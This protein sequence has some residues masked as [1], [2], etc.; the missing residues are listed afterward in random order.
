MDTAMRDLELIQERTEDDSPGRKAAMLGM[1]GLSTVALVFAMGVV[2]GG[3][4]SEAD[5]ARDEDPLAAL[6]AVMPAE[7]PEHAT[8]PESA[9]SAPS[10]SSLA[11]GE[12]SFHGQLT[13]DRPEVE[14][15]LAA[16]AA[17]QQMLDTRA[18]KELGTNVSAN[19]M[20]IPSAAFGEPVPV[21]RAPIAVTSA[22]TAPAGDIARVPNSNSIPEGVRH[23]STGHDGAFTL[24]VAS[25]RT[26]EEATIFAEALRAR[27]HSAY[28][29]RADLPGRGIY[30]R[31]RVGP[32]E[33]RVGAER[34]RAT[35]ERE[36]AMNSYVVDSARVAAQELA[37]SGRAPRAN[38]VNED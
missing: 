25:Y 8:E 36:E 37:A 32:F 6:A 3:G 5:E 10:E 23:A 24:Q 1:A 13:D 9:A 33:S 16:A 4:S 18:A 38:V 28:T 34:Y 7:E 11:A 20:Q 22:A 26:Q 35:F 15:A 17:E 21:A 31:V 30:F 19:G 27:G 2:L 12:V 29:A 14:A